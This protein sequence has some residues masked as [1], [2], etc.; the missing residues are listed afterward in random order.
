MASMASSWP[1]IVSAIREMN[2]ECV[3]S[4]LRD[5]VAVSTTGCATTEGA[6]CSSG[7]AIFFALDG[8]L[9]GTVT[10]SPA[11]AGFLVVSA[12]LVVL[13]FLVAS[14]AAAGFFAA[15]AFTRADA[16]GPIPA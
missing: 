4:R 8:F 10:A 6:T 16:R 9:A 3:R 13:V 7:S 15:G 5:G 11:A 1:A 2:C 12:V 14:F